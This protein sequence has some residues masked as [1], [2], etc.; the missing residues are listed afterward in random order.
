MVRG[1]RNNFAATSRLESPFA[2]KVATCVSCAVSVMLV[3]ASRFRAVSPEARSSCSARWTQG[4]GAKV[5]EDLQRG[6]QLLSG[7]DATAGPAQELTVGKVGAG[8]FKGPVR[9]A[10]RSEGAGEELFG[11]RRRILLGGL[12]C[13]G[14]ACP[15]CAAPPWS[16]SPRSVSCCSPRST[17]PRPARLLRRP[18][19]PA[20]PPPPPPP[21]PQQQAR[22]AGRSRYRVVAVEPVR[23]AAPLHRCRHRSGDPARRGIPLPRGSLRVPR[24]R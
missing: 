19:R 16:P 1:L 21:P 18:H 8:P 22:I 24:F 10:F 14:W 11:C 15:S 4:A 6:P 2:M 23:P 12:V 3:E 20:A 7:I 5:I 17:F 13:S 9:A